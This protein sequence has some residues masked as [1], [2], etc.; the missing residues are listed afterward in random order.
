MCV[1]AGV[2]Q[3]ASFARDE[4]SLSGN[5]TKSEANDIATA[6]RYGALPITLELQTTQTVS[7][8]L[9][10][11]ALHAGVAAGL[12]GVF[13]VSV[14][15]ILYYRW[16]GVLSV[17]SLV[18]S[19]ALMWSVI[20]YLGETQGLALTLAG[21]TGL[22]VSIGVQLDSSIMYF[23]HMK[24]QVWNGRTPTLCGRS[25]VQGRVGHDQESRL[26]GAAGRG[27]PLLPRGRRGEGLR[28]VP[29]AGHDHR[30]D[31]HL[32]CSSHRRRA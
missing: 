20:A 7:A 29:R 11:D 28:A 17:V 10:S 26:R 2:V 6:L 22:V 23:E 1:F 13:L 24:E 14:L 27:R 9:G 32:S 31:R 15:M 30:P 3:S 4:I 18:L 19:T 25:R 8:T 21:V 5:Y 12:I 16:F